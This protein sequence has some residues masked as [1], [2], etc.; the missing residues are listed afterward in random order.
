MA[1][2]P[3]LTIFDNETIPDAFVFRL[4]AI[5][6]EGSVS[7]DGVLEGSK[8]V[9]FHDT[10]QSVLRGAAVEGV[11]QLAQHFFDTEQFV[12]E[13]LVTVQFDLAV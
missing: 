11:N 5:V 10:D 12:T 8:A 9:V 3:T 13:Q 1:G 4:G 7:P 2:K 6:L